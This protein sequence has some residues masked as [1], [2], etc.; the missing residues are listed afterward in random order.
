MS[1]YDWDRSPVP[2]VA[3]ADREKI[4]EF[5]AP[6]RTGTGSSCPRCGAALDWNWSAATDLLLHI[7]WHENLNAWVRGQNRPYPGLEI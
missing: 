2:I 7:K 6:D 4:R 1:N 5:Y 3:D